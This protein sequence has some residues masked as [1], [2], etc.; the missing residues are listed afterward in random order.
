[1]NKHPLERDTRVS[2]KTLRRLAREI[3]GTLVPSRTLDLGHPPKLCP[4]N[5]EVLQSMLPGS[6]VWFGY[7]IYPN[8]GSSTD[9]RRS[10]QREI[11]HLCFEEHFLV[12]TKSGEFVCSTPGEDVVPGYNF[13]FL[14]VGPADP[15]THW[16]KG[17][18]EYTYKSGLKRSAYLG[19]KITPELLNSIIEERR[20]QREVQE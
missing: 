2:I 5:S 13:W 19:Q 12:R 15:R 8:N 17:N 9:F 1:M 14:A 10:Y 18:Y 7:R 16:F 3:G 6:E 11:G 20:K 4:I